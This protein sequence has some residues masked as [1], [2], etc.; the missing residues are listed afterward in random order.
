[1]I[2]SFKEVLGIVVVIRVTC[3]EGGVGKDIG[4]ISSTG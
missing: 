4:G 1:M 2:E 3:K